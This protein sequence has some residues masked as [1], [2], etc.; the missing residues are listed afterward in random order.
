[1]KDIELSIAKEF[2]PI[3]GARYPS[4]GDFSGQEFRNK[5]LVPKIKEAQCLGVHLHI[6]LDGTAGY[7]TSFLEEAFGGLIRIDDYEYRLLNSLLIFKSEEDPEYITEIHEYMQDAQ[8][9][10]NNK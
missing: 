7:G 8:S 5:L 4:E 3:P 2:S 6:D 1:M 9:K 10:K